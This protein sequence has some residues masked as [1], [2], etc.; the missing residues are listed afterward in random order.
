MSKQKNDLSKYVSLFNTHCDDG[1]EGSGDLTDPVKLVLLGLDAVPDLQVVTC[2]VRF[3]SGEHEPRHEDC[4]G[5]T[6]SSLK[7]SPSCYNQIIDLKPDFL[8]PQWSEMKNLSAYHHG[9]NPSAII[10]EVMAV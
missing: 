5:A 1:H 7:S 2:D 9:V 4:P 8:S 6:I 10:E 3:V